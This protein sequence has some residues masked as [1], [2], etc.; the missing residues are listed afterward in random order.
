MSKETIFTKEEVQKMIME[1]FIKGEN[2]GV[3]YSGWFMPTEE[4][5]TIEAAKQCGEIYATALINKL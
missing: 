1:A 2:W 3:T 5:K 4:E